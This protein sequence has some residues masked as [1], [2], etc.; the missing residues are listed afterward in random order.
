MQ[1]SQCPDGVSDVMRRFAAI[2][3]NDAEKG[4]RKLFVENQ[5]LP[6]CKV[7]HVS[8]G[9]GSL[10]K[11]PFLR[12]ST[13]AQWLLDSKRLWRLFCGVRTWEKMREVL[14]EFWDRYRALRPSHEVFQMPIDLSRTLPYF[15]HQDEGRGYKHQAILIVSSH[16][17]IGR[18]TSTYARRGRHLLPTQRSGL[19]LN[20]L[21]N[22][23][24]SQALFMTMLRS[25]SDT[26]PDAISTMMDIYARDASEL[27]NNGLWSEDGEMHVWMVHLHSKG[28]LPALS[29]VAGFQRSFA[30]VP[31]QMVS[32]LPCK[33]ICPWCLAG[34]EASAD[35]P[36]YPFEDF[37]LRPD[38][39]ATM[40]TEEPWS[41]EPALMRGQPMDR[42]MPASFF[43]SDI[44]HNYHVGVGKHFLANAF[45]AIVERTNMWA[46]QSVESKLQNLTD[47][48]QDYC[49]RAKVTPHLTEISK[50]TLTWPYSNVCPVGAWSKGSQTT[51]FMKFLQAFL[52]HH[53]NDYDDVVITAVATRL[54]D[55]FHFGG[56]RCHLSILFHVV[57]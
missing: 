34:R 24:S 44:W 22:T 4:C 14:S 50:S 53:L 48:F 27:A 52:E 45:V 56:P 9:A 55:A 32:R 28:D 29:K 21:G 43:S 41:E 33:G 3:L 35:G 19:G 30:H 36:G 8:L 5:C 15:S 10:S 38:W 54:V 57:F 20:F 49:R 37:S 31:R 23:W 25:A 47:E 13:W 39:L 6:P 12:L 7:E 46:G 17:C 16:G 18:G 2:P 11:F 26:N 51:H 40:E 1:V 42:T